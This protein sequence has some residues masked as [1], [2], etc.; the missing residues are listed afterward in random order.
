MTISEKVAY[1]KGL[2]EGLNLDTE[3]SK[4]GK[5]I[6]VM[7]GI[8]EEVGLSIED[9]EENALALG[10]EIDTLSDDLAD[11]ESVVFDED[12]D[13]DDCDDD[14]FEVECPTC[15]ETLTI[16]DQALADGFIQC[17]NCESKFS[18]DLSDD[19]VEADDKD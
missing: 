1:L 16:D 6:S 2:A 15:E 3:K 5:L 13:C 9:L 17:P 8:L 12:C 11:V 10:E 4:E 19:I 18:L 14:W 7:I